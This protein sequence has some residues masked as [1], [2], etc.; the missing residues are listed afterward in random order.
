M[1]RRIIPEVQA[2]FNICISINLIHHKT[3]EKNYMIIS[4]DT[5]KALTKFNIHSLFKKKKPLIIMMREHDH[6]KGHVCQSHS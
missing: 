4:T 6:N 3:K 2:L 5:E 1:S